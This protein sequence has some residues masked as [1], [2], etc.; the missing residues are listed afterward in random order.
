[1]TERE[2]GDKLNVDWSRVSYDQFCQGMKVE[3][4]HKDITKGDPEMTAKIVLAHLKE[5]PDY[6]TR[7]EKMEENGKRDKAD[8]E[9]A[10]I[11]LKRKAK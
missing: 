8:K 4:E 3:Q 2:V 6:Y 10:S 5:I 9:S 1:M 7:L 11:V